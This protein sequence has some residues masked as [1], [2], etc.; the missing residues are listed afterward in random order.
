MY[1]MCRYHEYRYTYTYIHNVM[2]SNTL[3]SFYMWACQ[4]AWADPAA[5]DRSSHSWSKRPKQP[6][7]PPP[8]KAPPP[9]AAG[10]EWITTTF[11]VRNWKETLDQYRVDEAAQKELFLLAQFSSKG[12]KAA[13][14]LIAKL[15]KAT[16]D[17]REIFNPSAFVHK[18]CKD[19]RHQLE[20][21]AHW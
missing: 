17:G 16:S 12:A 1:W 14:S 11:D 6:A 21:E 18:G 9:A 19:N 10:D 20:S 7:M 8:P 5:D 4:A 2:S 13:N 3:V 15:L